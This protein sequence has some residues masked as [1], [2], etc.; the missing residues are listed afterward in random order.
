ML[1]LLSLLFPD[2]DGVD[3]DGGGGGNCKKT[4]GKNNRYFPRWAVVDASG[5]TAVLIRWM[6]LPEHFFNDSNDDDDD[7]DGDGNDDGNDD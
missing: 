2:G 7:G 1:L 4:P 3:G 5:P 6:S